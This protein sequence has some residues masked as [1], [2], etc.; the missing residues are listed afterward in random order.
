MV[1]LHVII[2]SLKC[3]TRENEIVCKSL[4]SRA[5]YCEEYG[6]IFKSDLHKNE[7]G[8]VKGFI[9]TVSAS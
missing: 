1:L 2:L 8:F 4:T 7:T 5:L 6:K 3:P 9:H